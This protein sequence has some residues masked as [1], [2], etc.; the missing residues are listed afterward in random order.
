MK[1]EDNERARR[2]PFLDLPEWLEEFAENLVD[3]VHQNT[4]THPRVF[5][6]NHLQSREEKCGIG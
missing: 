6:V 5:S 1:N 4:E 3:D 2:D